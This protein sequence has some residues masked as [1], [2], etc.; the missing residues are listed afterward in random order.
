MASF[1][2]IRSLTRH[3]TILAMVVVFALVALSAQSDRFFTV[4]NLLNQGRLMTEV[5]LVAVAM[6]L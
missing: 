3:E 6:T 5:G 4:A 1:A 2:H